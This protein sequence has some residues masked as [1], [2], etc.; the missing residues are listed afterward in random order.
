MEEGRGV[1]REEGAEIKMKKKSPVIQLSL[2][3]MEMLSILT[4]P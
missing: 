1:E 4:L 3:K 2:H